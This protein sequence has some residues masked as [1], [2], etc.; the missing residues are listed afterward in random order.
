MHQNNNI[1]SIIPS[2]NM[3]NMTSRWWDIY[4]CLR[5]FLT[6]KFLFWKKYDFFFNF[7]LVPKLIDSLNSYSMMK[8]SMIKAFEPSL[9]FSQFVP[10]SH[11]CDFGNG[12]MYFRTSVNFNV[13]KCYVIINP[14]VYMQHYHTSLG[15]FIDKLSQTKSFF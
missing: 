6:K 14:C 8:K 11:L 15:L 1:F 10:P 9:N 4:A 2:A 3:K 13:I 12:T 7:C 5:L